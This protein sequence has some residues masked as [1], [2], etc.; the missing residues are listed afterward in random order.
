MYSCVKYTEAPWATT[1]K[2][3]KQHHSYIGWDN[4]PVVPWN[5]ADV[6]TEGCGI[7]AADGQSQVDTLL[8]CLLAHLTSKYMPVCEHIG[9]Y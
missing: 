7:A 5:Q 1:W 2:V 4:F 8:V 9:T 3:W 6:D